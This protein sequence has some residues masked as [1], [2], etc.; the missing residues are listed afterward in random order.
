MVWYLRSDRYCLRTE[1]KICGNSALDATVA[2]SWNVQQEH[3]VCS[4]E[5]GQPLHPEMTHRFQKGVKHREIWKW[6][7][8]FELRQREELL[9]KK[10]KKRQPQLSGIHGTIVAI[11]GA[12]MLDQP[13]ITSQPKTPGTCNCVIQI[14]CLVQFLACWHVTIGKSSWEK[15]KNRE[16]SWNCTRG[17]CTQQPSS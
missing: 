12:A 13:T 5:A 14:Y 1:T 3:N 7:Q 16:R 15:N 9:S 6:Y 8:F 17:S 11:S 10:E 4:G 2:K